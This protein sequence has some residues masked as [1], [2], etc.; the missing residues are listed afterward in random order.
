VV[1]AGSVATFT[2]SPASGAIVVGVAGCGGALTSPNTYATAAVTADCTVAATFARAAT[3]IEGLASPWGMVELPDGRWL[4]TERGAGLV[5]TNA[6]KTA[7]E[8]RIAVPLPIA[9][10][11]QGGLLDI[12]IDPDFATDPWVYFTDRHRVFMGTA[13]GGHR[14]GSPLAVSHGSAYNTPSRFLVDVL[15]CLARDPDTIV[16]EFAEDPAVIRYTSR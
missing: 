10:V 7:F 12:A 14:C 4:I 15:R 8:R 1:E 2:I 6:D 9:V 5:L 13:R 11:G 16:A 3:L